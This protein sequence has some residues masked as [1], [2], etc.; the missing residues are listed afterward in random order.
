MSPS[1]PARLFSHQ[2]QFPLLLVA[3][4][5]TIPNAIAC[6][7][8]I[9]SFGD[10][11]ADTGNLYYSNENSPN[12]C[13]LPPYGETHFHHPSGR[14][15]NGRLVI[16]FIAEALGILYVKPY[17]G[18]KK[19]KVKDWNTKEGVNF[20]VIG[21]T[22]LEFGFFK[23]KGF[24]DKITTNDSLR[25]QLD[26]FK[27]LL[28]SLCN[29]SSSFKKVLESSLFLV[30]EIGGNDFNHA[31]SAN[32]NL[33]EIRTYVPT[34]VNAISSAISEL[35]D[36]GAK[37]LVV[38]GNLP[39]GCSIFYL[40]KFESKNKGEYDEAGCLKWLNKFVEYYNEKLLAQLLQLQALHPHSKIIYADYYN[41]AMAFYRSPQQFGFTSLKACCGIGGPYNY[42]VS[43][44]CGYPKVI[45]CDDP[46]EY[47]GW[48]G[49]HLTE[50][51]YQW[52]AKA[53]L[54]GPYTVPKITNLCFS[55][56]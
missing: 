28:P 21:A 50:A 11:L 1:S 36:L 41:A 15:C 52:I 18:I 55:Q 53:L 10:S 17:L 20:A 49:L 39:I 4:L 12:D 13:F 42:N 8:S 3:A 51:A 25:I 9:F 5:F 19:G 27:E 16:D 32:K 7:T 45:A 26:W 33:S 38:P 22:A 2:S 23:E 30:G 40:T 14:C 29:S 54:H 44:P 35:V 48:D 46:S 6:F 34:V 24:D 43:V 56:M 47:V 37:T 31:F